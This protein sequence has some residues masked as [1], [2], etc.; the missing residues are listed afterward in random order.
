MPPTDYRGHGHGF[1]VWQAGMARL[2]GRTIGLDG[3]V[4]QQPN[5]R[6]SGFVLAHRNI[7]YGGTVD[8]T[9]D[10]VSPELVDAAG[11][12]FDAVAAYDAPFFAAPRT[13]FL[14]RWLAAP[15]HVAKAL[16][17]DGRVAGYGV[18]RPCREGSKIGPL[19]ADDATAADDLFRALAAAAVDGPVYLDP[20]EPNGEALALA[21]R[22]GLAAS[23]ETARMYAGPAPGLPLARTY[24]ITTFELG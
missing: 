24:G 21:E 18:I 19:F 5:Y 9:P 1:R 15:G 13:G 6:K 17:R 14:A 3:V 12:P 11:L 4:D 2:A 8:V 10:A 16:L 20:P 7:R 23:F 22:Y